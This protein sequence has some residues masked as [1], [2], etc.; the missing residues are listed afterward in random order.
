MYGCSQE[1]ECERVLCF[2]LGT[3]GTIAGTSAYLKKQNPNVQVFLAD[4]PGS[5]L[6]NKVPPRVYRNCGRSLLISSWP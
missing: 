6:Y 1:Y 5:S 2:T 3:G 4:P